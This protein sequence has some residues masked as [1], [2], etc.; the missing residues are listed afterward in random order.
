MKKLKESEKKLDSVPDM[1][2]L[3]NELLFRINEKPLLSDKKGITVGLPVTLEFWHSLPFWKAVFTTLGF[4][5]V[6]SGKSGNDIFERGIKY[7]PSDT[8]CFPSKL[9]HGHIEELAAKKLIE[10]LIR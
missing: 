1:F 2:K 8:V 3:H 7:I 6:L 5:I 9:L 4:D 10:F